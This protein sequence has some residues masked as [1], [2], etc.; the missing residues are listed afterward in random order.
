MS[1]DGHT[2]MAESQ[3]RE[4]VKARCLSESLQVRPSLQWLCTAPLCLFASPSLAEPAP[5]SSTKNAYV[6][7]SSCSVHGWCQGRIIA[8][9]PHA[10][11][12]ALCTA[13]VT[14]SA[15]SVPHPY[16]TLCHTLAV[17]IHH[18]A[19]SRC[20]KRSHVRIRMDI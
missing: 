14:L 12:H 4:G 7:N 9:T 10:H 2:S 13:L 18:W 1:R 17:W 11:P 8:C 15:A 5:A 3:E 6:R 19:Q 16:C 20:C